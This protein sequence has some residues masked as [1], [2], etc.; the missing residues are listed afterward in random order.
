MRL[1]LKYVLPVL[2]MV[3]AFS[4]L[5][6]SYLSQ[7]G[8]R[9]DMCGPGPAFDL[10][11]SI[12]VPVV[13]ARGFWWR[14]AYDGFGPLVAFL[15][16]DATVVAAVGLLWYWMALNIG[17]WRDRRTLFTFQWLPLRLT[18]DVLLIAAGV[19]WGIYCADEFSGGA[20][21]HWAPI[22][23]RPG[24]TPAVWTPGQWTPWQLW[25]HWLWF[26]VI[27]GLHAAWFLILMFPGGRDF[28]HG[29]LRK[30]P[31]ETHPA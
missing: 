18:Q 13:L 30:N 24:P 10:L 16:D 22:A 12:N 9:C 5:R 27:A 23:H 11:I 3:L 1:K 21:L 19:F 8:A 25:S 28:L 14:S 4:L 20:V 17:A 15:L 31:Q 2:Q 7:T 26:I 29:V 6:L